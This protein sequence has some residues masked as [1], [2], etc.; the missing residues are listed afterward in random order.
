MQHHDHHTSPAGDDHALSL[1]Q[2]LHTIRGV[3]S[4]KSN[5]HEDD[6]LELTE[7]L[8]DDG[9]IISIKGTSR[10]KPV[11]RYKDFSALYA[12]APY[13]PEALASNAKQPV[14]KDA[15]LSEKSANASA[16]ALN[17]LLQAASA[18]KTDNGAVTPS[19]RSGYTVEDLVVEMLKPELSAWLDRNLPQLIEQLVE[20]EI[21]KI[22]AKNKR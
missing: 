8:A 9:S 10:T 21:Q 16:K 19:F 13:V 14:D 17:E 7:M 22:L 12:K 18:A 1:E 5:P 20:N 6:V 11:H 4:E 3:I 15:L 2:I